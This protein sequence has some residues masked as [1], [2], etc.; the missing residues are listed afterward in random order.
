MFPRRL[1]PLMLVATVASIGACRSRPAAAP[2]PVQL[3]E[4]VAAPAP[5]PVDDAAERA[6]AEARARAERE[7]LD[8]ERAEAER[9]RLVEAAIYFDYDRSDLSAEARSTLDSKLGI[10]A[11]TPSI[12]IRI[13]GHTDDRGSDEYNIALGQR[14][15]AAAKRYLTQRGIDGARVDIVSFGEEQPACTATGESCWAQ[16]RR[17]EFQITAGA[18]VGQDR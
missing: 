11:S 2:A 4:P 14:R 10:L 6:A 13:S 7:R 5:A 9:R 15:A 18:L 16:N 8:R 1:A 3:P 17:D 12:R